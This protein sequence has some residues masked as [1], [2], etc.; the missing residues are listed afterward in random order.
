MLA[1]SDSAVVQSSAREKSQPDISIVIVS[2]NSANVIGA[3]LA[4]IHASRDALDVET[5]VVDNESSDGSAKLVGEQF[6]WAQLLVGHGNVGFA[7]GNNLGFRHASGRYLFMLNPDTEVRPGALSALV[8]FANMH[9]KA[10]MIAPHVV[11]PDGTLQHST[12]RFPDFRQAFY[13]FFE[14]MTP[15]D[16]PQN[17][18]YLPEDYGRVRKVEHIL[19][20]AVFIRREV[21]EQTG[22]MDEEFGLFFEE[23]DWCFRVRQ[24]G[25]EV[26]YTP[27][28]TIMHVSAHTTSKNPERSS[29]LFARSR[30]YFYRKNYGWP[31]YLGLK[32]I[33][34]IGLAYWML[35]TLFAW[36]RRG[37]SNATFRR[38]LGSYWQI[39]WT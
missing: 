29:V 5:I 20:A 3:C 33:T 39:L 6:P 16:S 15:L 21:Y 28:A 37:I 8:A 22:G 4:S 12:F 14:K 36:L 17:G 25:W 27:D 13:G 31:G 24:L 34:I 18:R 19:G 38:R 30:A 32:V 2:Y 10:G 35:R 23:T 9:P 1:Q 7:R 26:L 11:N